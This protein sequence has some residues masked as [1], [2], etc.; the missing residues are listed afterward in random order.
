MESV[1]QPQPD[2]AVIF[3]E[4]F[5]AGLRLPPHLV[6]AEILQK[7]KV[8]LH[9]LTPNA[10]VQINLHLGSQLMRRSSDYGRL[11]YALRVVL[12]VEENQAWGSENKLATQFGCI[13]FH[14]SH[15]RNRA[16]LIL[17][18]KNKWSSGWCWR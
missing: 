16:R 7:F 12:P 9:Q 18:V 15:F 13:S 17:A 2:K 1:L 5:A 14:P 4:F 10:I 6:L 3:E 11:R 8:Q